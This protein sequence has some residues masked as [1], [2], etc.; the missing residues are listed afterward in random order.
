MEQIP[1]FIGGVW[2][3]THPTESIP[4]IN[5]AT[6]DQIGLIA[7]ASLADIED[8]AIAAEK[9]FA[10]WKQVSALERATIMHKAANL[11]RERAENIAL[12]LTT[13]H[14]KPLAEAMGEVAATADTIDWHAEEGRR[15]YGRVI[16]S[17]A[18]GIHQFTLMEPIGPVVGFAPW[19]FPLI[20]AVKKVAGALAAGCSIILKGATEAPTC[21]V[22]L[23]K[24]FADAGVSP[25]AVNLLF[26]DSSQISEYLIAHPSIR[27]VTFTGS[28]PVGKKL[29]S[30][31]GLHMKRS[32]MEL[33]GHAPVIVMDDADIA[34]A[35]KISVA[36]KYRNAG[37]VCVSPTRFLVHYK[38]FDEFV[39]RFVE[40]ARAIKVGDGL[41]PTVTMGPMAHLGRLKATE[42]LVADAV[43]HG[44][45]L[46]I[47]GNRVGD[48]GYFFE[49]TVLTNVPVTALAMVDEP[50]GP[51]AI[52]N[53]FDDIDEAIKEANRL[54]YGL[55][56]YAYTRSLTSANKLFN[57]I[58]SGAISINHHSVALPE[59]PFGGVKDSGYGTEGGPGALDAFMTTKFVSLASVL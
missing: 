27:K 52:I 36:A 15:A 44:A 8:A 30:L 18:L 33:G 43:S 59:H 48:K 38:V 32:T 9:G 5:P 3:N 25:G 56:A 12:I 57:G 19:N 10:A 55:S 35:V 7:K 16:P 45:K 41:D 37:Q 23:V 54:P 14:G 53:P 6:E 1:L 50:F 46:E 22:E 4:V 26:G 13:E 40:G 21:A 47:G 51:I 29:A 11:I 20:Q 58:E 2:R 34:T 31:A 42:E 49:P 28:T 17:R 39:S 24:A